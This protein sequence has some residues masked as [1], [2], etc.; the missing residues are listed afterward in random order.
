VIIAV[1]GLA[2]ALTSMGPGPAPPKP[3]RLVIGVTDKVTDIDPASAYDF[4][5]WEVLNN[6]M[7]GLVQYKPGTADIVPGLA[8]N[9]TVSAD[10]L[11]YTFT[12]RPNLKFSDGTPLTAAD[13][14]RSIDRVVAINAPEGPSWLISSF[15][16]EVTAPDDRTIVFR[17][18]NPVSY[19]LALLATPPYF[20]VHPSYKP[21]AVDSDQTAGGAGP[22]KIVKWVRDQ[23][24][25][26]TANPN[27]WG[28]RPQIQNV[29]IRFYKDAA[30]LRTALE[31]GEIHIAWRTLNPADIS[32][33]STNP[34]FNVIGVP[35]AFIRYIIFN[36]RM[37]PLDNPLVRQA[38]AAAVNRTD[39]ARRVFQGTVTPLFTLVPIGMWSHEDVFKAAY[40]DGNITLARQLLAQA[41]YSDTNKLSITLWYTP[42]HYGSTEASLA[43]V[44]K[45]QWE[46]TGL[47]SVE[48]KSAEW[49]TYT[50][51]ASQ[52]VMMAS[53]F[54]WYPDYLD[55]DD[56]LSP[57]L[58][59]G[60]NTWTGSG[61][62]NTQVNT[63]L[64]EARAKV[65][66]Q[67]RAPLY[68]QVQSI[69]ARDAPFV[70]LVQGKLSIVAGK[71]VDPTSIVLGPD[72]LFRYWLV[73]WA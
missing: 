72:M 25:D 69:L 20:P 18:I 3:S 13:V 6:I 17:L 8:S 40:G 34:N 5:T 26:L 47:V 39:I 38:L 60:S 50:K 29:T 7:A 4:F 71:L 44:L 27:F 70:P 53:L 62:N 10:G 51:Q 68:G 55:P 35:G 63:L 30:S 12:L 19:F 67:D 37:P 33:L 28:D 32:S 52:G 16:K 56:Y 42:S 36:T 46:S 73:R 15:V 21:S 11:T 14:K 1:V 48:L 54:G 43:Q 49:S 59:A 45:E 41:G 58:E 9:W 22:Y 61:Y 31:A 23:E 66:I 2:V 24:L 64:A 57:F 65:S